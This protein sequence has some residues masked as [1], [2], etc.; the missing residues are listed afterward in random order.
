MRGIMHGILVTTMH[1]VIHILQHNAEICCCGE[2][3]QA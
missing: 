2:G 1:D 3:L